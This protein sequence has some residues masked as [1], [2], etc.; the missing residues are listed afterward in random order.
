MNQPPLWQL[1]R[2]PIVRRY[3]TARLRM[4]A[5]LGW[6]LPVQAIGAFLWLAF[7]LGST[8]YGHIDARHA[9]TI[10]WIPILILQGILWI[11]KGTFGVAVGIARE[12]VEG[13]SDAQ[14]L[15]PLTP[16]HKVIGYLFGLPILET[17]LVASLLPW[18]I[19]S[20]VIGKIP[21]LVAFRIYLLLATAATLH[22]A[23]GLVTGTVIR[24]KIVAGTVSQ[25]LVIVLHFIIPF[26]SQLGAG[27]LGHL[28][29]ETS[30]W[31][32]LEPFLPVTKNVV[33]ETV[34]FFQLNLALTGYQWVVMVMLLGFLLMILWRRWKNAEAHLFSKPLA[35]VFFGWIGLMSLGEI[36][37]MI[38]SGTLF[39]NAKLPRGFTPLGN[40]L[41]EELT[42]KLLMVVWA[43]AVGVVAFIATMLIAAIIT[44][45]LDQYWC[46]LRA[47]ENIKSRRIPWTRDAHSAL[48]WSLIIGIIGTGG[49]YYLVREVMATRYLSMVL[50]PIPSMPVILATGLILPLIAWTLLLEWR[51]M[52]VAFAGAFIFWVLPLMVVTIAILSGTAFSGWPK[53]LLAL[54]GFALPFLSLTQA[55]HGPAAVTELLEHLHTPWMLSLFVHCGAIVLFWRSLRRAQ[56]L[57]PALPPTQQ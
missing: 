22:H 12:S 2:N 49:W 5:L 36:T 42:H 19:T 56:R 27:P 46:A 33:P 53:W 55:T 38:R 17:F 3:A 28:G 21:L 51:G 14:R 23:I 52:K 9:A 30:M 6:S 39:Q 47:Q 8:K 34:R 4:G 35:L 1:W 41:S 7:Y 44:P 54:S 50:H 15:T 29:V 37:P 11:M 18:A 24:Q 25:L 57:I 40:P 20:I 31:G 13:L 16:W 45:T 43:G 26:F 32:E 48:S 10:A